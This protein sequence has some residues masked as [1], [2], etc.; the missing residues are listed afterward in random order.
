[1]NLNEDEYL[2]A[3]RL[4]RDKGIRCED[5]TGVGTTRY[6]GVHM[7]FNLRDSFPILTSKKVFFSS[8]MV[9]LLWF[10]QGRTDLKWLQDRKCNIWNEWALEDDTIG[11]GYGYQWRKWPKSPIRYVDQ[12]VDVIH[13]IK[14]NPNSRRLIVNAWNTSQIDDM[15]L[16]PCHFV[17]QFTVVDGSLNCIL[18]QRSG[19][20]FLGV[21]FN[22][23]SYAL[24]THLIAI[25]CELL[26]GELI[27]NIGDA[28]IYNNHFDQVEEQLSRTTFSGPEL[29]I[30]DEVFSDERGLMHWIDNKVKEIPLEILKDLIKLDDYKFHPYI[31]ARVAV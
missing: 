13:Q 31:K 18:T 14:T 29:V 4:V 21:P 24:L 27:H 15:A 19:D 12:I 8:V 28:H 3:L 22:I 20:M 11:V 23:A 17:F 30:E 7:R 6:T 25:E 26:P 1:V 9:E 16:P 5:R 2:N 10:L